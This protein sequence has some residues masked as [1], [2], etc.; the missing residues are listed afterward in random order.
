MSTKTK[1]PTGPTLREL[2]SRRARLGERAFKF[3]L[4][5]DDAAS[6]PRIARDARALA[7]LD[8]QI[9]KL[10][11]TP[12]APEPL[13]CTQCY[14]H[15]DERPTGDTLIGGLCGACREANVEIAA[16][17]EAVAAKRH[18]TAANAIAALSTAV[19]V[20]VARGE[21]DLNAIAREALASRGPEGKR[22]AERFPVDR[23]D[24][25]RVFV[26]VPTDDDARP[27]LTAKPTRDEYRA[28]VFATYTGGSI[29]N[30]RGLV[31]SV[32]AA[33]VDALIAEAQAVGLDVRD[34][35]RHTERAQAS[36]WSFRRGAGKVG[37]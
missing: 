3:A 6:T 10:T 5:H 16:D 2:Q 35:V 1:T 15:A 20:S 17:D 31:V 7:R 34:V 23:A 36:V 22:I 13:G 4:D 33:D 26:T 8:R 14:R 29:N 9:A 28:H 11:G 27:T 37:R 24:G 30:G 12:T 25:R 18:G 19:L 21:V 32:A